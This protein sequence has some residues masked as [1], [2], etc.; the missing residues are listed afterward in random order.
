M[1]KVQEAVQR[2]QK[3]AAGEMPQGAMPQDSQLQQ[4]PP[5][6]LQQMAPEQLAAMQ[7]QAPAPQASPNQPQPSIEDVIVAKLQAA[8]CAEMTS[9]YQ[10]VWAIENAH[11]PARNYFIKECEE[12]RDHELD[13]AYAIAGELKK[14]LG[15]VPVGLIPFTLSQ[16][17]QGN[18]CPPIEEVELNVLTPILTQQIIQAE[19]CAV[20]LYSELSELTADAYPDVQDTINGILAT[21]RDH[22][23]DMMEIATTIGPM[24]G[25]AE[26][27][28]GQP[29][30]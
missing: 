2:L 25:G 1:T 20:Q 23:V 19:Q 13:H 5:E 21:E 16:V 17:D 28:A 6:V 7:Q 8:F 24:D 10:Y 27:P 15:V 22:V 14:L 3:Q 4:I 29:Q 11:G 26:E 9:W 18:P 30:A 12:H